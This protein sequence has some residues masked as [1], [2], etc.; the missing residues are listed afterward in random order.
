MVLSLPLANSGTI[1]S[2]N[3]RTSSPLYCEI[4]KNMS[5]IR[6]YDCVNQGMCENKSLFS[7]KNWTSLDALVLSSK[8]FC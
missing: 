7:N 4:M 2:V 1:L 6:I 3:S 5:K 8:T